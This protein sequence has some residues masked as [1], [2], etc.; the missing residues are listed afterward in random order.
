MAVTMTKLTLSADR[1]LVR[2]A[3]AVAASRKTS[4]SALC[5]SILKAIAQ[6]K[7]RVG[8]PLPPVT[9]QA[10]GLVKLPGG[11]SDRDLL[12]ASLVAKYR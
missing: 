5:A 7:N 8:E 1:E 2:H 3:K 10:T 6:D 12:E 4:V 9:R 11:V